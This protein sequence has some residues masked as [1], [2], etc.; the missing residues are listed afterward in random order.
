[1]GFR[2]CRRLPPLF[3]SE[4]RVSILSPFR[5]FSPAFFHLSFSWFLLRNF[6]TGG[7]VATLAIEEVQSDDRVDRGPM[8]QPPQDEVESTGL[9]QTLVNTDLE[10]SA[11]RAQ[12]H[13]NPEGMGSV[14]QGALLAGAIFLAWF[15]Y[16]KMLNREPKKKPMKKYM[17]G[18]GGVIVAAII[19][20]HLQALARKQLIQARGTFDAL[21]PRKERL[22]GYCYA[23]AERANQIM[24]E[25]SDDP[26]EFCSPQGDYSIHVFEEWVKHLFPKSPQFLLR[27]LEHPSNLYLKADLNKHTQIIYILHKQNATDSSGFWSVAILE[28]KGWKFHDP[29]VRRPK[30]SND[31]SKFF[32]SA[33]DEIITV[34]AFRT[35]FGSLDGAHGCRGIRQEHICKKTAGCIWNSGFLSYFDTCD[36][37]CTGMEAAKCQKRK[38]CV[39][40]A[41]RLF[42]GGACSAG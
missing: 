12:N 24:P 9:Q 40:K 36:S 14:P 8:N 13:N 28:Q 15:S 22:D 17:A 1:M 37:V 6:I 2:A 19:Y 18:G 33:S 5:L 25:D 7:S 39:W 11:N 34:F 26:W 16:A 30:V 31:V 41:N 29:R 21:E 4:S 42:P 35:A 38:D 20:T 3:R 23:L 32:Q 27:P 10:H